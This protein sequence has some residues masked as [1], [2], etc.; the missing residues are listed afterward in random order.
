MG[1]DGMGWMGWEG[2]KIGEWMD[3]WKGQG[4]EVGQY[5]DYPGWIGWG[6]V[7]KGLIGAQP[8]LCGFCLWPCYKLRR[9]KTWIY[10]LRLASVLWILRRN[11][12]MY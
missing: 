6:G 2:I 1:W 10:G 5:P 12:M 7:Q 11:K 9:R 8:V 3:G 4:R